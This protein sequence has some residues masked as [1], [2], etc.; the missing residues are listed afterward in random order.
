[1]AIQKKKSPIQAIIALILLG[2]WLTFNSLSA[3]LGLPLPALGDFFNPSTGFWQQ[4]A[5]RNTHKSDREISISAAYVGQIK[6]SERGVPHFFAPDLESACYLQGYATASDRLFQMDLSSRATAGRLSEILGEGLIDYD[7]AQIRRG[8]REAAKRLES[9]WKENFPKEYAFLEAYSRGINDFI[10]QLE[11]E[12]YPIEFKL[13]GHKPEYWSPYKSALMTKGM[14]KT[15]S[16]RNHDLEASYSIEQLGQETFDML[17][18]ER[19]PRQSPI[20]SPSVKYDFTPLDTSQGHMPL[21]NK[22]PTVSNKLSWW[23]QPELIDQSP[24]PRSPWNGSNNWAV[25][26]TKSSTRKPI[27]ANDP[28]LGLTL[29]S[30]WYEVQ[31]HTQAEGLLT[32][33]VS[34]PGL[35]LI[36]IG[37]NKDVAWGVTNCGHDVTD[38]YEMDWVDKGHTRYLLDSQEMEVYYLYDTITIKDAEPIVETTPWTVWG[39]II[40]TT[41]DGRASWLSMHWL[42]HDQ[43]PVRDRGDLGVF[44]GLMAASSEADMQQA[45]RSY[46]DPAQNFVLADRYGNIAMRPSGGF[47]LRPPGQGRFVLDG[48]RSDQGWAG[49]IP[50]EQRP[51]QRNP[52]R[53]FVASAN[54]RTTA[55][56]YP[57]HYIGNFDDYRGRYL[58]R[59]LAQVE[60]FNQ[61]AIKDLQQDA[62][63][64][65][66]EELMPYLLARVDREN[67]N[68]SE[69]SLLSELADWNYIYKANSKPATFFHR[70]QAK[71]YDLTIDEIRRDSGFLEL[72]TWRFVDL[73]RN[74]PDHKI[75]DIDS[76][77]AK[78]TAAT[79]TQRAFDE[80]LESWDEDG[81]DW[82][83][84]RNAYVGHLAR[85]NGFGSKLLRSPGTGQALN[86]LRGSSGPS[87]RMVVELGDEPSAWGVI[88]GG[89]S[90]NPA[91]PHYDDALHEWAAGRYYPLPLR[92]SDDD[93]LRS[94]WTFTR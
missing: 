9:D 16:A 75:F 64:L 92:N 49:T 11:P 80:I 82:A 45:L 76:T 13:I 34:L 60:T 46:F 40:D 43:P 81:I 62:Y 44:A 89:S 55:E 67:M 24:M 42:S 57:Y 1:M 94:T 87:W 52:Q 72:E 66:A 47:P 79:L 71:V 20:I 50:P 26:P 19:N 77:K 7:R 2:A 18:P 59:R 65:Y 73:L 25:G 22:K 39:P 53:G 32:R 29:P 69:R 14:S 28:H 35:P 17:F 3:P 8:Y 70:W 37:F 12:D 36:V 83:E 15:L 10:D 5:Y 33:G 54:Q 84:E 30:I 41:A 31:I 74:E 68:T 23:E 86:A 27:L 6:F 38:W 61:R 21:A 58:N 56:D 4:A 78:E 85:I 90:G 51:A 48:S 93:E 63:S 88:P 91:S